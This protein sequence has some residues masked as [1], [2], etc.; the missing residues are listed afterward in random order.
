MGYTG[1][2]EFKGL[3]SFK[4]DRRGVAQLVGRKGQISL[5][6]GQW[7]EG[8]IFWRIEIQI[9]IYSVLEGSYDYMFHLEIKIS[10]VFADVFSLYKWRKF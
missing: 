8:G 7:N 9:S 2:L 6:G 5:Y 3:D 4:N 10:I 1:S